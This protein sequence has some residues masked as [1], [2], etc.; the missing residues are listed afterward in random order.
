VSVRKFTDTMT[1]Q[2][3]ITVEGTVIYQPKLLDGHPMTRIKTTGYNGKKLSVNVT[4]PEHDIMSLK[5][6]D[7]VLVDGLATLYS[8]KDGRTYI[9]VSFRDSGFLTIL[10]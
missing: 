9:Q 5:P 3:E 2:I 8:K 10:S 6:G 4:G 1:G 7:K